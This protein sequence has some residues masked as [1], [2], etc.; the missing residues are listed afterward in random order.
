MEQRT[1][2]QAVR[3]INTIL[4][5]VTSK[6]HSISS[7]DSASSN[8]MNMNNFNNQYATAAI[9]AAQ[10]QTQ[11]EMEMK[12]M[13]EERKS[14]SESIAETNV[15]RRKLADEKVCLERERMDFERER[16]R[17]RELDIQAKNKMMEAEEL[18]RVRVPTINS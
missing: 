5:L 13:K 18:K 4:K 1:I 12:L 8:N 3:D 15:E 9:Q 6:Q 2:T 16:S 17:V 11:N 10:L 7:G 14:L